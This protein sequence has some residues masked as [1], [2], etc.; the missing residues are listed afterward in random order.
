MHPEFYSHFG[1]D[2]LIRELVPDLPENGFYVDVGAGDWRHLSNTLHFDLSG[3]K[4]LCIEANPARA[5]ILRQN[6]TAIVEQCA[7]SSRGIESAEYDPTSGQYKI[8]S[9][10]LLKVGKNEDYTTV[11]DHLTADSVALQFLVPNYTLEEVLQKHNVPAIDLISIDVEGDEGYAWR[12]M[13]PRRLPRIVIMEY[14]GFGLSKN[15]VAE[16]L[17]SSGNYRPLASTEA[18]LIYIKK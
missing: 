1:E 2:R 5:T 13:D 18:N 12:S 16:L 8:R 3:W 9:M 10:A 17:E 6:R 4:G 14:S 7:I 15:Q 11:L